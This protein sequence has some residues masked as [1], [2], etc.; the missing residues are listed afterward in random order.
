MLQPPQGCRQIG[1]LLDVQTVGL[2][3]VVQQLQRVPD[4]LG[5]SLDSP[6][7]TKGVATI[8]CAAALGAAPQVH[9][10]AAV[11]RD[12]RQDRATR[13]RASVD[14]AATVSE[15]TTGQRHKLIC[16]QWRAGA[17]RSTVV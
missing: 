11:N 17:T 1:P 2:V 10:A 3:H 13:H 12:Q 16:H 9:D 6:R 15:Q 8:E 5:R 14:A 4:V 7:T